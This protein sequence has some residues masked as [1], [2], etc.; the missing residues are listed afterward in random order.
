[1]ATTKLTDLRDGKTY[2]YIVAVTDNILT[3]RYGW[4]NGKLRKT[5]RTY[6]T[7]EEAQHEATKIIDTKIHDGFKPVADSGCDTTGSGDPNP[8][9]LHGD[10][11]DGSDTGDLAN[12][13]VDDLDVDVTNDQPSVAVP[14]ACSTNVL[15]TGE[16][17]RESYPIVGFRRHFR[18]APD[19]L[20]CALPSGYRFK[21]PT[22]QEYDKG[23]V[24]KMANLA[25]ADTDAYGAPVDPLLEGVTL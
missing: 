8:D 11:T 14:G 21:V 9:P 4:E 7:P 16:L 19:V 18:S 25:F 15:D 17:T 13:T 20:I 10:V 22:D 23:A 12:G 5:S 3:R 1:M 2:V 6:D 24:G